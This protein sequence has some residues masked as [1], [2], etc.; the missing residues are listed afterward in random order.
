MTDTEGPI[1]GQ[2]AELE[3]QNA[4]LKRKV[5]WLAR[6]LSKTRECPSG[7]H[8]ES[9]CDPSYTPLSTCQICWNTAADKEE[10][11]D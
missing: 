4:Q 11:D 8:L 9:D 1:F 10:D 6:E 5:D 2:A 3:A 7:F